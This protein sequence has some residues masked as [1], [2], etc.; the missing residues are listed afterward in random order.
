M[1][2]SICLNA[3]R[4]TTNTNCGREWSNYVINNLDVIGNHNLGRGGSD[5]KKYFAFLQFQT[6]SFEHLH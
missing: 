1:R 4:S 2:R 5:F 3:R 6:L